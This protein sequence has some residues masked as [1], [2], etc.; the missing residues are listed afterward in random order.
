MVAK[1]KEFLARYKPKKRKANIRTVAIRDIKKLQPLIP[2]ETFYNGKNIKTFT[3]GNDL[4]K[5]IKSNEVKKGETVILDERECIRNTKTETL[6]TNGTK[7][8]SRLTKVKDFILGFYGSFFYLRITTCLYQFVLFYFL[9]ML[10]II[11]KLGLLN[12]KI[13]M[14]T[15]LGAYATSAILLFCLILGVAIF[16]CLRN[17]YLLLGIIVLTDALTL[18]KS[19]VMFILHTAFTIL[20]TTNILIFLVAMIEDIKNKKKEYI[21]QEFSRYC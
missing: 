17:Y 3:N 10:G 2:N 4:D 5:A 13:L 14:N 11:F 9:L 20:I 6:N 12:I 18:G 16:K 21:D 7:Y 19:G 8:R 15:T 1:K